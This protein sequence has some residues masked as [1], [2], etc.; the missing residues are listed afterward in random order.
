MIIEHKK[1][2]T[3]I[4]E[5]IEQTKLLVWDYPMEFDTKK[6]T[7]IYDGPGDIG[8]KK[9]DKISEGQAVEYVLWFS[10]I[11]EEIEKQGKIALKHIKKGK[12]EETRKKVIA[13]IS[14][15]SCFGASEIWS[16]VL[17]ELNKI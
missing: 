2:Q 17:A 11:V 12:I 13:A 9:G 7:V 3:M 4:E 5:A 15:E 14:S 8:T 10:G 16:E 6:G 1:I